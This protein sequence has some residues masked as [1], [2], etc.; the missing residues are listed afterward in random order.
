MIEKSEATDSDMSFL[1]DSVRSQRQSQSQSPVRWSSPPK[2][3]S[4]FPA[5]DR[6]SG[7]KDSFVPGSPETVLKR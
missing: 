4:R 3:G 5:F 2:S 1:E 7:S 6:M